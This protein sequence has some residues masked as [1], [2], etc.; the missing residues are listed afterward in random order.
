MTNSPMSN[1]AHNFKIGL[2]VLAA[3]LGLIGILMLLGA[4]RL[5]KPKFQIETYINGSVQGLTVGSPL[6]LRGV[7]IGTVSSI[8]FSSQRY[9][10]HKQ[11]GAQRGYVVVVM[12]VDGE[13]FKS[14]NSETVNQRIQRA[15]ALG[16]RVRMTTVGI[17][18]NN[19]MEIDRFVPERYPPLDFDWDPRYPYMPS[20]PPLLSSMADSVQEILRNLEQTDLKKTNE[21]LQALLQEATAGV[22]DMR[23]IELDP[24]I[25]QANITL[26]NLDDGIG[27]LRILISDFNVKVNEV[28][29]AGIS[30]ETSE[31]LKSLQESNLRLQQTM[32]EYQNLATTSVNPDDI[33]ATLQNLRIASE[34]LRAAS[35]ELQRNPSGMLLGEPPEPAQRELRNERRKPGNR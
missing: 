31:L 22:K 7:P 27:D 10:S 12:E 1:R 21:D 28:D 35:E 13:A 9:E 33:S 32:L 5:G 25:N 18:G 2:F 34:N 19:F 11:E 4:G 16:Y 30:E 17:T 26:A 20:A 29:A 6:K 24:V 14:G 3:V 15:S 8:E 23:A